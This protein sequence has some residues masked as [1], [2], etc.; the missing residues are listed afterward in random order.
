MVYDKLVDSAVLDATFTGIADAIR[1]KT[2]ITE[3]FSQDDMAEKIPSVYESG[4]ADGVGKGRISFIK[5]MDNLAYFFS[6]Q[7]GVSRN[8]Q[9]LDEI[10]QAD[11]S[12]IVAAG[13]MFYQNN[14]ITEIHFPNTF[15]PTGVASLC[16][17]CTKLVRVSGLENA[18]NVMTATYLF[19]GCKS[20]VDAGTIYC[21]PSTTL[22]YAFANCTALQEIRIRGTIGVAINLSYSEKLSKTSIES[23][24]N[25]LST[26]TTGITLSLSRTAVTS[27]FGSTTAE[28]WTNLIGTKPNWTISLV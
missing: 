27:A 10:M 17:S 9:L 12:N 15:N 11:L 2:S 6:L 13:Y 25:A 23:V 22:G 24:I 28:K 26:T 3:K 20:L 16:H 19:Y 8:M 21:S 7:N 1:E 5:D 18:T 14:A 4:Q